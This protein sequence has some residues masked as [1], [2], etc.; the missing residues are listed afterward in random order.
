[1]RLPQEA[2]LGPLHDRDDRRTFRDEPGR[3]LLAV[4]LMQAAVS[5]EI[6]PHRLVLSDPPLLIPDDYPWVIAELR[7]AIGAPGEAVW[8]AAAAWLF[9]P[10][11]CDIDEMFELRENSAA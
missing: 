1:Q 5:G 2:L 9:A 11:R 10:E 3:Q 4:D 6:Q 8:A 7:Q